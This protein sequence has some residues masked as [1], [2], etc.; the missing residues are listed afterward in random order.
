MNKPIEIVPLK[1]AWNVKCSDCDERATFGSLDGEMFFC[2]ECAE[3]GEMDRELKVLTTMQK[4]RKLKR[5]GL[6]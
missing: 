5:I 4:H 1:T 6:N 3:R 2:V